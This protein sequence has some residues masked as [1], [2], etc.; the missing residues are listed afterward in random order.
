MDIALL[1]IINFFI[2]LFVIKFTVGKL[3]GLVSNKIEA[4][5]ISIMELR[6]KQVKC[7]YIVI[8]LNIL[9]FICFYVIN[10]K[11][12]TLFIIISIINFIDV[13]SLCIIARLQSKLK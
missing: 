13:I 6:K 10:F 8:F 7:N 11:S 1:M 2:L 3:G 4:N 5:D 9:L 12:I